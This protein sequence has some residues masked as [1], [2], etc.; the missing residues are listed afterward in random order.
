VRYDLMAVIGVLVVMWASSLGCG[1][2]LERIV[3]VRLSNALLL[4]LGLCVSLVVTF[5]GYALG[6]GDALAIALL[7]V[8]AVAGLVFARDGLPARLN[9]GWP[10]AA[11]LGAY[12]LYMLPVIAHGHWTW[13]GYDFVND[14]AFEMLMAEHVKGFGTA[15]GNI[16]ETTERE[17]LHSYLGAGYPLGSQSLLGT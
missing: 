6:A 7:A 16:P 4:P 15:L 17:F 10:G 1:L 8:V 14:S 2:A 11:G 9:P 12:V 5:P 3:G 13:S